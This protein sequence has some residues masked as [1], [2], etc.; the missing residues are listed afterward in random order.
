MDTVFLILEAP[1]LFGGLILLAFCA[2]VGLVVG[3]GKC[4]R[5]DGFIL[6]LLLGPIGVIIAAFVDHRPKCPNCLERLQPR[7]RLC[8]H[9][10]I[11][12]VWR[13]DT[14]AMGLPDS[15]AAP[16]IQRPPP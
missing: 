15:P 14:W 1:W 10:K 13:S 16:P 9:C 2:M 4:A 8:W 5:A 7:A 12:L 11:R 3:S 6:G